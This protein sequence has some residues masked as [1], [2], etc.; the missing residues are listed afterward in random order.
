QRLYL[1]VIIDP[2][3]RYEST[4][5][6]AQQNNPSSLLW[7][8]KRLIALRKQHKVFGRGTS[9][10]LR[11]ENPKV[12]AFVRSLEDDRVLVVANL[13]RSAQPVELDL[14]DYQGLVPVE[15]FG[16]SH[17]PRIGSEPYFLSLGPHAFYWFEL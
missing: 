9:H 13:S 6:E 17:F 10:F 7:W 11:P 1:P 15:M 16:R 12:L 2:E 3:Y 4:N 8:M 14:S 5:V